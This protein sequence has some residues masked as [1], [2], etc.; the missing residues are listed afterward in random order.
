MTFDCRLELFNL[1]VG[2]TDTSRCYA[3]RAHNLSHSTELRQGVSFPLNPVHVLN[4]I[5]IVQIMARMDA[6]PCRP[7]K[8]R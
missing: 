8:W 1:C 4:R 6:P 7:V 5:G 2:H 3:R